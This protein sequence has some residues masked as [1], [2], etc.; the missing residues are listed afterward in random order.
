MGLCGRQHARRPAARDRRGIYRLRQR[1][2]AADRRDQGRRP[3][4]RAD[5]PP[6]GSRRLSRELA[7]GGDPARGACSRRGTRRARWSRRS[8][9][10]AFSAS[11]SSSAAT[12]RSSP[13]SSPRP[14]DTGMVTLI[15]QFPNEFELHLRAI[16][17]LPIPSI[18]LAGP[19]ASA[20]ILAAEE[21]DD[22][23]Y[24]GL[25]EALRAGRSGQAGRPAD[26]RQAQDAQEPPHGG[27][28]GPRRNDR[29]GGRTRRR[30]S[31]AGQDSL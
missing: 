9:A 26:F 21:S 23:T 19:S 17:G 22:F 1:D 28:A 31:R 18:E 10:T 13:S 8:A 6:A 24:E 30:C 25:A 11:N 14:H 20:V 15:S 4:L 29:R 3:V 2:H 12:R 5:R 16:L 27:R 7:A